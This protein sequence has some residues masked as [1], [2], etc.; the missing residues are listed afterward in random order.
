M[1]RFEK[2]VWE[3]VLNT[4]MFGRQRKITSPQ[5][6]FKHNITDYKMVQAGYKHEHSIISKVL[7]PLMYP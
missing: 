7:A 5:K 3:Q 4:K 2:L 6:W 1:V